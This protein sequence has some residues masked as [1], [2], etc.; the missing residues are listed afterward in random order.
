MSNLRS[1]ENPE[2]RLIK[3]MAELYYFMAKEM[4]ERLGESNGK[5]AIAAAIN[6]FGEARVHA[7]HREAEE[8]HLPLDNLATYV[9]VRDMPATGWVTQ[10]ISENELET[11]YCPMED[12][13]SQYGETGK[14]LGLLYCQIDH[15]LFAGFGAR[16]ERPCCLANGD[17][18]CRMLLKQA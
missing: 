3:L 14:Q 17:A 7:M 6:R 15:I 5:T 4:V 11:A 13:W 12:I 16:L 9:A 2:V 1:S 10:P 8:R 18:T